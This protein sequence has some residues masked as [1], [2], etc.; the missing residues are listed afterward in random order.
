[1][2]NSR[3]R[4]ALWPRLTLVGVGLVL[5][6]CGGGQQSVTPTPR[7]APAS[8]TLAT[9]TAGTEAAAEFDQMFIDMMVPHH[10]AATEMAQI[11]VE[12][13][14][15][16]ELRTMAEEMIA[17][18]QAEITQL[19]DW[20]SEWYGSAETPPM[21][22]MPMLSEMAGMQH[23][24]DGPVMDMTADIEALRNAPEPF[25]LAFID[26]MIPHH[27]TAIEA[28]QLAL[29]NAAHPELKD[30]A[31][32]IIDDQQQEITQLQDWR[33]AW[34]ADAAAMATAAP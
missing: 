28:A 9:G 3:H 8:T 10:Q 16:A 25:D 15:H 12:R 31:Q 18:Q 27:A 13:A 33:E 2:R 11:A 14:E 19:R 7:A 6:A 4:R 1:M 26:A 29:N 17:K 22:A 21:S 34:Y 23:G 20:R 30:M 24:A 32:Q 5:A